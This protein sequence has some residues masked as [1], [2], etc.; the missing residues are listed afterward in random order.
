MERTYSGADSGVGAH[1]AWSG[2][3]RAGSGTMTIIG[4]TPQQ[5]DIDADLPQAVQ[6]STNDVTFELTPHGG[7]D[8]RR[9]GHDAASS[10]A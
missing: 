1:Y 3:R 5:V 8:D 4:S 2:N 10:G 7:C 6:A 9:V